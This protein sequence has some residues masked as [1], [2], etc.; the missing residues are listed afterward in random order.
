M[1]D[2]EGIE[3]RASESLSIEI[4]MELWHFVNGSVDNSIAVD[5]QSGE[6]LGEESLERGSRVI[7]A[8][9]DAASAH[10][11]S[12]Q[13]SGWPPDSASLQVRLCRRDW[14]WTL[15]QLERWQVYEVELIDI[16]GFLRDAMQRAS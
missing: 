3:E 10:Q 7:Q 1:N 13:P 14:E 15:S 16:A 8:G 12:T 6:G 9:W 4:P 2:P 5:V 11:E